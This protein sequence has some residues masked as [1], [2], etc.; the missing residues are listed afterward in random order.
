MKKILF[1]S[2]LILSIYS[3][4][5]NVKRIPGCIFKENKNIKEYIIPKTRGI[6]E[7]PVTFSIKEYYPP[8]GDQG[9][10]GTCT[11]WATTYA[12]FTALNNLKKNRLGDALKEEEC[13]SPQF[14]Y[15]LIKLGKDE[16]CGNGSLIF[17][18]LDL[19]KR[20]GAIP[21]SEYPYNCNILKNGEGIERLKNNFAD[22]SRLKGL[23]S[24]AYKNRLNDFIDLGKTNVTEKIKY[25]L[26]NTHP[27]VIGIHDYVNIET[28]LG[29]DFWIP[30]VMKDSQ[31][32]H[33]MSV[34]SYDD[35]K[36]GGSF[37]IMNSWGENWGNSGYCWVRYVDLEKL[38]RTA[39][40]LTDMKDTEDKNEFYDYKLSIQ[41]IGENSKPFEFENHKNYGDYKKEEFYL[42]A[43]DNSNYNFIYPSE[44]KKFQIGL[45]SESTLYFYLLSKTASS[46]VNV[47]Y[48]ISSKDLNLLDYQNSGLILPKNAQDYYSIKNFGGWYSNEFLIL[49]SKKQI[50]INAIIQSH[51]SEKFE[52][53]NSFVRSVFQDNIVVSDL[54]I[55]NNDKN[56]KMNITLTNDNNY[57]L[58]IIIKLKEEPVLDDYFEPVTKK[59]KHKKKYKK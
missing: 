9:L 35:N 19:L 5:Q 56:N 57:I 52:N 45:S 6:S 32:G 37:E 23:I 40:A 2:A 25:S 11:A 59:K 20:V 21:L 53:L 47:D 4:A 50:N 28:N 7:T 43:I 51:K 14:T 54:T 55:K 10:L 27:V 8:V 48:P 36:N 30:E 24:L 1:I 46:T 41:L 29:K 3:N 33:A 42:G 31:S 39:Y 17:T 15:D 38:I 44:I 13:F 18:A 49:F 26:I 22:S 34:V 12:S 58:P 16:T